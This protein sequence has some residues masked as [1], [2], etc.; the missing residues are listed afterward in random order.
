MI[1]MTFGTMPTYEQ[2]EAQFDEL[3]P[4][5]YRIRNCKVHGNADYTCRELYAEVKKAVDDSE[6]WDLD[7][8]NSPINVASS[9]LY[10]LG[11]EW[12]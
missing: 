7:N 10:T 3:C 4:D 1:S 6:N 11:F 5:T 9:I 8:E 12:I 2:F